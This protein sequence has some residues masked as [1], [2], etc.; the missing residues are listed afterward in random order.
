[1]CARSPGGRLRYSFRHLAKYAGVTRSSSSAKEQT[2]SRACSTTFGTVVLIAASSR[3]SRE[4]IEMLVLPTTATGPR[5]EYLCV[6]VCVGVNVDTF[7]H[8]PAY[9]FRIGR[10]PL[11][12]RF[13]QIYD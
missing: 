12:A 1:M 5:H 13:A 9:L 3:L 11:N 2:K 10:A 6:K 8:V 7:F 4:L